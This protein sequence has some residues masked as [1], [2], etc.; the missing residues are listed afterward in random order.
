MAHPLFVSDLDGTLLQTDGHLSAF[1]RAT[2]A[3][4]TAK[5]IPI[6][7]ASGRPFLPFAGR[8]DRL[9]CTFR[10][11]SDGALISSFD[12]PAPL[13]LVSWRSCPST[14]FWTISVPR[15]IPPSWTFGTG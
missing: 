14:T 4:L 5:G 12:S 11:S 6:T 3:E 10:I 8:S 13:H 7:V 1:A 15:V 9:G 2:L